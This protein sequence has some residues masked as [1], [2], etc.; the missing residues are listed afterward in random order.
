MNCKN[1]R[2]VDPSGNWEYEQLLGAKV[3]LKSTPISNFFQ[4]CSNVSSNGVHI[5]KDIYFRVSIDGKAITIIELEDIPDK[6]FT[7]RDIEI[8]ELNPSSIYRPICGTFYSGQ[9]ICGYNVDKNPTY[10]E[11]LTNGGIVILSD[12]GEVISNRYVRFVGAGVEPL[13][14]DENEIT[15]I[16]FNGEILD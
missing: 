14:N 15:D 3:I 8:R 6:F 5:I 12:N 9:A 4:N 13:F 2:I 11:G 10:L 7:W 1:I 16:N